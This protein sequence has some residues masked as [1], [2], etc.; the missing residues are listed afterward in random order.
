MGQGGKRFTDLRFPLAQRRQIVGKQCVLIA[1]I[2]LA[3]ADANILHRHQKQIRARLFCKRDAQAVDHL[4]SGFTALI[5]WLE[6]DKHHPAVNPGTAGK[7]GDVIHRRVVADDLHKVLQFAAHRLERDALVG[8]NPPHQHA[9]ILLR[10]EGF[11]DGNI[12]PDIQR[13]GAK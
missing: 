13:N 4:L 5:A 2:G 6:G 9:R 8:L 7:T 12:K 3:A 1:G 10:E 11:G